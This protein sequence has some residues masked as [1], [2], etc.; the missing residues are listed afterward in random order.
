MNPQTGRKQ[1]QENLRC[2]Q[3]LCIALQPSHLPSCCPVFIFLHIVEMLS[4]M[5][6]SS[7]ILLKAL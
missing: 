1:Q 5:V 6:L 7:Q 2:L 4:L 3:A